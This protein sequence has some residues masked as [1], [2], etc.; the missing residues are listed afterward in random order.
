MKNIKKYVGLLAGTLAVTTV[1]YGG[2]GGKSSQETEKHIEKRPRLSPT[3]RQQRQENTMSA[4]R[5]S[6]SDL[7]TI[8]SYESAIQTAPTSIKESE[9]QK[10]SIQAVRRN[11]LGKME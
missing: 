7:Y 2:R 8:I 9:Q 3:N 11:I 6:Q 1:V 5:P 4:F 10:T